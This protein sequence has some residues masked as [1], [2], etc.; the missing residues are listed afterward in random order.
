LARACERYAERGQLRIT[1]AQAAA[2]YFNWI[3]MGAPVNSAMLLGN[4][5]IPSS[6]KLRDHAKESVRIFLSAFS[7]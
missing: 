5:G 2:S 6:Q 7:G 1:D 4:R 3:V